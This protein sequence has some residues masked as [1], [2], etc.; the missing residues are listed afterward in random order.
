MTDASVILELDQA[1]RAAMIHADIPA[2]SA[3]FADDL[4]W[5]HGNAHVDT[6]AGIL[7]E[8]GSGKRKYLSIECTDETVRFFGGLA[9]LTAV[10]TMKAEIAAG[11][12]H[13]VHNRYIIVW[14]P[15]G[16]GWKVVSWQSTALP[17]GVPDR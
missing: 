10:A 4:L 2:L 5:I 12:I 6:K 8:I 17:K 1:R 13:N 16:D 15:Y 11:T 3:M 14:A 9:F 7:G